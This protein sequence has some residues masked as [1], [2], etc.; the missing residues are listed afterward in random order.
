M[1][2]TVIASLYPV[3]RPDDI[4]TLKILTGGDGNKGL[5][6]GTN[7]FFT[8]WQTRSQGHLPAEPFGPQLLILIPDGLIAF[9]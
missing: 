4:G 3:S 5:Y 2:R 8:K 9:A 7:P 6:V 1:D